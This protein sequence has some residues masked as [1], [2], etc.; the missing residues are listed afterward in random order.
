MS[1]SQANFSL[2]RT[3][4]K[5][6]ESMANLKLQ[7]HFISQ[8][9][10]YKVFPKTIDN[11]HLP[12]FYKEPRFTGRASRLKETLLKDMSRYLRGKYFKCRR[13]TN[14]LN[15]RIR[16]AFHNGEAGPMINRCK[17]V[18]FHTLR[19]RRSHFNNKLEALL[20]P[21]PPSDLDPQS[22]AAIEFAR[23]D[24]VTDMSGA[25][26]AEE[27]ALLAKGPGFAIKAK[28]DER[29]K[30]DIQTQLCRLAY[31]IRWHH[32][33][34]ARA[35]ELP[36]S[37][38]RSIPKYPE[39]NFTCVPPAADDETEHALRGANLEIARLIS[40]IGRNTI[41]SNLSKEEFQTLKILR[42]KSLVY[43]PSDKGTEF[44]V[45]PEG[46]YNQAGEDHLADNAI[47]ARAKI[48]AS[49]IET[50]VNSTWKDVCREA[51]IPKAIQRSYMV[52][53]TK[54]PEFYHLVKT[55][56]TGPNIKIRPIVA[57]RGGPTAKLAWLMTRILKPLLS[58]FPAHLESS[59][60]LISAINR[61]PPDVLRAHP[62]PASLDVN[63]LYTSVPPDEAIQAVL[64]HMDKERD[65]ALPLNSHHIATILKVIL[66]N[67]FFT[68]N[69]QVYRQVSGLPM[70]SSI[71]G[72]LAI[73]FMNRLESGPL[74]TCRIALYKRYVDDCC[75]LTTNRGEAERALNIMNQQHNNIKFDLELPN[76]DGVLS[77]LD[78][79][80]KITDEG[81]ASFDFFQ[82]A[83]KK[84]IFVNFSSALPT[85]TKRAIIRNEL[86][87]IST[88]SSL[89]SDRDANISRFKN[90]LKLNDYPP[91]FI[92]ACNVNPSRRRQSSRRKD[93]HF[94][95][96]RVP[97]L[98]DYINCKITN[99]F[100]K[101]NLP[102]RTYHR[103][104][105]LRYALKRKPK[106]EC[107]LP[108][109]PMSHSGLCFTTNSVYSLQCDECSATYIGSTIRP[110][111]VRIREHYNSTRSSVYRHKA[112]C[113]ADF[114]VRVLGKESDCTSLRIREALLIR[115]LHPSINSRQE[116]EEFADLLF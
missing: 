13:K 1:L 100:K 96:L 76:D 109:C 17:A 66:N 19:K 18:Y 77:L 68:F 23:S 60:D 108:N 69:G 46:Q 28:F 16:Q 22:E 93:K 116:R 45:I 95:Y 27:H 41:R 26:G 115:S 53:N 85:C 67:T 104:N 73:T 5:N 40:S 81:K 15:D 34:E 107:Q 63:A 31:Q 43:L 50:R 91:S 9:L 14:Q 84:P 30:V 2:I 114:K 35:T 71:S 52:H 103:S 62:Y 65:M 75:L 94:F 10:N 47:Y 113:G 99:I 48:A 111:H 54:L 72:L 89:D 42:S 55:H 82:K 86:H 8:C 112:S 92:D 7:H 101:Y 74:T 83:A 58:T 51:N 11:L 36:D 110:L 29:T 87:R 39:S 33:R 70:G 25:L 57:S 21:Q 61:V 64:D 12:E 88:R 38:T 59:Y 20:P 24:L 80:L 98:S 44:C 106:K 79:S 105:K 4:F 3:C 37:N 56:K 6:S 97:F 49:T 102:V 32:K 90:V 78:F